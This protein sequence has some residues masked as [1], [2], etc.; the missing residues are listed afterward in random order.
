MKRGELIR[1]LTAAGCVLHHHGARHHVYRNPATGLKQ[2]IPRHAEIDD[3]L[4]RH[5]KRHLG[6]KPSQP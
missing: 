1:Q 2:P 5:I 6:L 3:L 4:A